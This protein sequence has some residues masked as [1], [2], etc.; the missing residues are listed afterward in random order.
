VAGIDRVE[1][2][3]FEV[4]ALLSFD[5]L[6]GEEVLYELRRLGGLGLRFISGIDLSDAL[7]E[8]TKLFLNVHVRPLFACA[9]GH[10]SAV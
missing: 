1:L 10:S 8:C 9:I 3:G 2:L 5:Y 7:A 6:A 4:A